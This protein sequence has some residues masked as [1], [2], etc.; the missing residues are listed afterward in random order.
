MLTMSM[1]GQGD[2]YMHPFLTPKLSLWGGGGGL[3]IIKIL[4]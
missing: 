1:D 4:N 2:S 3:K